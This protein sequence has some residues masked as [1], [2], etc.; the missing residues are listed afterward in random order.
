MNVHH[1]RQQT[2][3]IAGKYNHCLSDYIASKESGTPDY[4]GAFAVTAGIGVD[5]MVAD[6]EQDHDDYHSIMVKA[7]ADRLAEALAEKMHADVRRKHWGYAVDETLDNDALIRE[8]Y[9][10]IRP[11]PGYPACP[12][13]TEKGLLWD[14]LEVE[15]RIG[16]TLTDSY[17]MLP[18][19]A[20]SGWYFSH[21]D[22]K[23]FGVAKI[24][25]DQVEDYAM[26]KGIPRSDAERWLAPNLSYE[27]ESL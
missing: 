18:T 4:L 13:H 3:K 17:A 1:L 16:M 23:Y 26:R 15:K 6:F 27:P 22:A 2:Q 12:D 25:E 10:G 21:P 20:V 24:N 5:E 7:L 8:D 19:A 9:V 14:L 11:A